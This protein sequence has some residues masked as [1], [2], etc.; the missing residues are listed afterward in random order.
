MIKEIRYKKG[1]SAPFFV[2][3]F[4]RSCRCRKIFCA[5]LSYESLVHTAFQTK[6]ISM[7]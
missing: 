1:A 6:L 4:N 2:M 5:A 3:V 7:V